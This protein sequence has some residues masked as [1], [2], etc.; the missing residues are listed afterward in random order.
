MSIGYAGGGK[1]ECI[2][3][4]GGGLNALLKYMNGTISTWGV[5][6]SHSGV[7][8]KSSNFIPGSYI[9]AEAVFNYL[10]LTETGTQFTKTQGTVSDVYGNT[11]SF[12]PSVGSAT[13]RP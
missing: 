9:S 10:Y 7:S 4:A 12:G 2:I 6:G 5:A 1:L 3:T 8:F 11:G 13:I